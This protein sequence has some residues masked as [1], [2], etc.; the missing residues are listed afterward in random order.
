MNKTVRILPCLA[1]LF[2]IVS[3][4]QAGLSLAG[5]YGTMDTDAF[6]KG[7]YYGAQLEC[8][9]GPISAVLRGGYASNFESL[10]F[11]KSGMI[12]SPTMS[13]FLDSLGINPKYAKFDDFGIVPIEA[14]AI[15]RFPLLGNFVD[16]YGGGGVGYYFIPGVKARSSLFS[17][18]T[19]DIDDLWGGWA[20]VGVEASLTIV[21]VFAEAKYTW[22]SAE[23]EI[24]Y[25]GKDLGSSLDIDLSGMSFLV[26]LRLGF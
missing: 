25:N 9:L 18:E 19:D 24:V 5:L 12:S 6:D 10:D 22:A 15:V 17:F 21:H 14:G 2:G 11:E 23:K 1:L 26:G 20:C 3:N 13:N 4:A 7:D 16:I 8:G